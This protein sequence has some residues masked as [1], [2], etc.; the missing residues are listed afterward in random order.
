MLYG[1]FCRTF[2]Q[3]SIDQNVLNFGA[4]I[5][6]A[7]DKQFNKIAMSCQSLTKQV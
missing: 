4:G 1:E 7:N 2:L 3:G 5:V 6:N